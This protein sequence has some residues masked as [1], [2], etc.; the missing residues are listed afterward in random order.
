MLTLVLPQHNTGKIRILGV[1]T[2]VRNP[3]AMEIPTF[4]E[5]GVPGY[6]AVAWV[7]LFAPRATP[8]RA[9]KRSARA[10]SLTDK[11]SGGSGLLSSSFLPPRHEEAG[12]ADGAK[13]DGVIDAPDTAFFSETL[14]MLGPEFPRSASWIEASHGSSGF[15]SGLTNQIGRAHV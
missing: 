3:L 13:G 6:E 8:R 12:S 7:G 15:V 2:T 9:S 4:A 11:K 14:P 5:G 10:T 1:T